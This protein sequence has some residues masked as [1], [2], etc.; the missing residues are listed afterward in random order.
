M[1]HHEGIAK[2]KVCI[3][4]HLVARHL[5]HHRALQVHNLIVRKREDILLRAV[6]AHGKGHIVMRAAPHNGIQ[7]HVLA[8]IMH[9]AHVPFERK[10]QAFGADFAG[11]L[12]PCRGLLGDGYK[13]GI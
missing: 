6:I 9:P 5:L 11:H 8:E 3:L 7:L 13:A 1:A 10:A 12:R 4:V 2:A